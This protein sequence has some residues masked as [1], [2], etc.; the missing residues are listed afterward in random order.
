MR[1]LDEGAH[2]R[3]FGAICVSHGVRRT[4]IGQTRHA[5]RLHIVPA[6]ERRAAV[7]AH[8][9]H[10]QPLVRGGGKAV[11]HPQEGADLHLV[12]RGRN[13]L[14]SVGRDKIDFARPE[15]AHCLVSEVEIGKRFKG[16]AIGIPL[17]PERY[18]SASVLV[19]GGVDALG[20]KHEDRHGA[21]DRVLRDA[22]AFGD[23]C[24]AVD[25]RRRQFG[26]V[27]AS[28]AHF[29]KMR[30]ASRKRAF[31]EFVDVIDAP[32]RRDGEVPEVRAHEQ[33]L[34]LVV[35]EMQPMPSFPF[36]SA[37][38]RSN[39]VRKGEFSML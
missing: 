3:D 27:D 12:V 19:A 4:R 11:V 18:G 20:G 7:V 2:E 28:A 14:R 26:R 22:Y 24:A 37:K 25:E 35:R 10:V 1:V 16:H 33:R 23:G 39:L 34:R 36:I 8:L 29:K 32:D 38:S 15:F 31:N 5:V 21:I 30:F 6:G 9:L 13:D 17:F